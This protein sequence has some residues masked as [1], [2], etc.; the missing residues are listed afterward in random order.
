MVEY[1]PYVIISLAGA[2]ARGEMIVN[3]SR[4]EQARKQARQEEQQARQARAVL[5][6]QQKNFARMRAQ[7]QQ[8]QQACSHCCAHIVYAQACALCARCVAQLPRAQS[9]AYTNA[10]REVREERM[11]DERTRGSDDNDDESS[12]DDDDECC[13]DD[14]CQCGGYGCDRCLGMSKVWPDDRHRPPCA[15]PGVSLYRLSYAQQEV[16]E[17]AQQAQAETRAAVAEE[18]YRLGE[19]AEQAELSRLKDEAEAAEARAAA[20]AAARDAAAKAAARA[21]RGPDAVVAAAPPRRAA[22]RLRMAMLLEYFNAHGMMELARHLASQYRGSAAM[23]SRRTASTYSFPGYEETL[24]RAYA[25]RGLRR[26]DDSP[27]LSYVLA[28]PA[29]PAQPA[30]PAPP[31]R[32]RV[33]ATPHAD[34]VHYCE[35]LPGHLGGCWD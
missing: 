3:S 25:V 2:W 23:A 32:K 14:E 21:A 34:R 8:P 28:P 15:Q 7:Q 12:D 13:D 35:R 17:R 26:P 5:Q 6:A 1:L 20:R 18:W 16:I 10:Y 4:R 31:K 9:S 27:L 30:P 19:E 11:R 22:E 24:R 29:P 33:C